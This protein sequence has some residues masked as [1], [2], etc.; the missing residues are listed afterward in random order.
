MK[1]AGALLLALLAASTLAALFW[2]PDRPVEALQARWAP[3][4]SQFLAVR[5][6][7]LHLRDEGPRDDPL[8]IVLLHGTGSSLHT[9]EGWAAQL[10]AHRRVIRFDRPGFGL[11]GPDPGARYD[12]HHAATLA[13]EIVD[14]LG[15][16]RFVI[17][18]NSSGGRVAW[19]MALRAPERVRQLVLIAAGGYPR[20]TAWPLGLRIAQSAWGAPLLRVMPRSAV[21]EGVRKMYGDPSKVDAALIDRNYE[22]TLRQGNRD[23]LGETLRQGDPGN[24]DD[25]QRIRTPTLI[26]WG[27]R[28]SVIPAEDAE[29]FQRDIRGSTV[30]KFPALGHLPQEEDPAETLL[31]FTQWM[32]RPEATAGPRSAF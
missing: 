9:W 28:D 1:L 26:L 16:D 25:I 10:R 11:T 18:G 15:V 12:M 17:V 14:K 20:R 29:L 22:L 27:E 5:G 24:A 23:A 3:P 13:L 32:Q 31:A 7:Q 30:V 4:P 19:H 6:M 2:A 21:A 8:P